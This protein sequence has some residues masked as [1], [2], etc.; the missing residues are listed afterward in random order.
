MYEHR[1]EHTRQLNKAGQVL[2]LFTDESIAAATP[3][4]EVRARA[5]AIL[6]RESLEKVADHILQTA[7][8][9]EKLFQ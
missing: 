7:Q 5:F 2:K 1:L 9:D 3:F 8:W 4:E 6:Q